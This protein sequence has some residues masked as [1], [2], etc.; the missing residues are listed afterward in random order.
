MALPLVQIKTVLELFDTSSLKADQKELLHSLGLSTEAG[1]RLIEAYRLAL[2]LNDTVELPLEPIAIGSVLND[3]AHDLTPLANRYGIE[4]WLDVQPHLKPAL[5]HQPSLMTAIDCLGSSLIR[6]NASA[7]GKRKGR[8]LLGAHRS[9][10]GEII[11][12]VFSSGEGVSQRA[13]RAAR[14]L[15]GRARQPLTG[16]PAG[17]ASGVL[18]ADMLCSRI[19]RPLSYARH[20]RL[21]GLAT[22]VPISRQLNLV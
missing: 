9:P 12:G 17:T 1:L 15:S 6:A 20:N 22:L 13:L 4:I 3:V 8:V 7:S 21:D 5:A 18:V 19:W 2:S 16:V 14:R 10:E 11:T